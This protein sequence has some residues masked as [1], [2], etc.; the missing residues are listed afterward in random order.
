M[1]DQVGGVPAQGGNMPGQEAGGVVGVVDIP[2]QVGGHR[3]GEGQRASKQPRDGRPFSSGDGAG[4]AG[5]NKLA[6]TDGGCRA[7]GEVDYPKS[8]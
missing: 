5:Q 2:S 3:V 1:P 6:Q 7:S 8:D 4:K